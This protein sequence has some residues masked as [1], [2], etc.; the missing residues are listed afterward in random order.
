[1]ASEAKS[2][3]Y[4]MTKA[5][6][7]IATVQGTYDAA[8]R[9]EIVEIVACKLQIIFHEGITAGLDEVKDRMKASL[10]GP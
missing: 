4:W 10:S 6:D 7:I 1:M 9:E 2:K 3:R 8:T 5:R